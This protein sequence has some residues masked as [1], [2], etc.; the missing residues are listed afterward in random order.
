MKRGLAVQVGVCLLM[1][2]MQSAFAAE[3]DVENAGARA[4]RSVSGEE[5]QAEFVA[6]KQGAVHLKTGDG[7]VLK[8]SLDRLS[9]EDKAVAQELAGSQAPEAPERKTPSWLKDKAEASSATPAA[10]EILALFGEKLTDGSRRR[11]ETA[12]LSGKQKI[13]IYFSAHWCPPCRAFTPKLVETRNALQKQGKP[14][15]VVFVSADRTEA[16]M[17][18]YMKEAKMPWPAVP[19]DNEQRQALKAKFKVSGIPCLVIIDAAGKVLSDDAVGAVGASGVA[20]YD[21]W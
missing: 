10:P 19:Y 5:I 14:F 3:G 6:L 1:A 12:T 18:G 8:I 9:E 7:A 13:G 2:V 4:W 15:E 21:Q 17:E 20:A 11:V 16:D